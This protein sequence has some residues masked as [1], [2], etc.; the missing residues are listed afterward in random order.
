MVFKYS[1]FYSIIIF[2][3]SLRIQ[4]MVVVQMVRPQQT[5]LMVR[6]VL[7]ITPV[8]RL[9]LAVVWML[10]ILPMGL[11]MRD[12]MTTWLYTVVIQYLA[13]VMMVLLPQRV[14]IR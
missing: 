9:P 2:L 5:V 10:L 4:S 6:G 1:I 8:N 13:A 7:Y 14:S 3:I 11:I 12:V